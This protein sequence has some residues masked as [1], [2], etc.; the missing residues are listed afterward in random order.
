MK[1]FVQVATAKSWPNLEYDNEMHS[2]TF[3]VTHV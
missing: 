2:L 3:Y 1:M